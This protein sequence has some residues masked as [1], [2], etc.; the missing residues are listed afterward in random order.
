MVSIHELR[1]AA[2]IPDALEDDE[3][4][5]VRNEGRGEVLSDPL[6]LKPGAGVLFDEFEH[7]PDAVSAHR[8]EF[9]RH[10]GSHPEVIR[11]R[12]PR[13]HH[14]RFK[15]LGQKLLDE[16]VSTEVFLV[17]DDVFSLLNDPHVITALADIGLKDY[18]KNHI[19]KF[20]Q[21]VSGGDKHRRGQKFRWQSF[22]DVPLRFP[23]GATVRYERV[24]PGEK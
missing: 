16:K 20:R 21:R 10:D 1:S 8:K 2:V 6:P 23:E 13:D 12:N 19:V 18:G 15:G 14:A 11:L 3:L 7:R 4:T 22:E 24:Y 9:F 17:S 5:L